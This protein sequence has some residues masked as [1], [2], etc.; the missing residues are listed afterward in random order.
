[1]SG[2]SHEEIAQVRKLWLDGVSATEI[3]A[4]YRGRSRSA[5]CGLAHR[6]GWSA[7]GRHAPPVPPKVEAR[8]AQARERAKSPSP[9]RRTARLDG[10][11]ARHVAKLRAAAEAAI[12]SQ[13]SPPAPR[14]VPAASAPAIAAVQSAAERLDMIREAARKAGL[15]VTR[16]PSPVATPSSAA[17]APAAAAR[18]CAW[19]DGQNPSCGRP[20]RE[21]GR[22][23]EA[24]HARVYQVGSAISPG[25]LNRM[26]G[27]TG[28]RRARCVD[29]DV[30]ELDGGW[31]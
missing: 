29:E 27:D 10:D 25:R 13:A 31:A 21:G 16:P 30:Q 15:L 22:Y 14:E 6:H 9:G 4:R 28:V 17:P 18:T 5:I 19:M 3:A 20:A 26:G 1:M 2:W 24:H 8:R 11:I 7:E 12:A 23:C